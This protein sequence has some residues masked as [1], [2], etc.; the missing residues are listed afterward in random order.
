MSIV[1]CLENV[2]PVNRRSPI[3]ISMKEM[4]DRSKTALIIFIEQCFII[5]NFI[6]HLFDVGSTG[7]GGSASNRQTF[8]LQCLVWSW[9]SLISVQCL[10]FLYAIRSARERHGA[11]ST[12][13]SHCWWRDD[14]NVAV[15]SPSQ[16]AY[17]CDDGY[18]IIW[19]RFTLLPKDLRKELYNPIHC[20]RIYLF[21]QDDIQ[22]M[23]STSSGWWCS[24]CFIRVNTA[25]PFPLDRWHGRQQRE[26]YATTSK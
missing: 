24:S 19:V 8:H 12:S 16:R 4:F 2:V 7:L 21:T 9:A 26:D 15:H 10:P 18:I 3:H 14:V 25:N 13:S 1:Q 17:L 11:Q 23:D 5:G 20:V 6:C 22:R